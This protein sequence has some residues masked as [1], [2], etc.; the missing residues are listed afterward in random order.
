MKRRQFDTVGRF[1]VG[2]RVRWNRP[3]P[4]CPGVVPIGQWTY[5]QDDG[6]ITMM[7]EC[8]SGVLVTITTSDGRDLVAH[9][10]VGI[11][12]MKPVAYV[13]DFQ[14]INVLQEAPRQMEITT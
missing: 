4:A 2:Q 12:H 11:Y 3:D 5:I 14:T 6:T 1:S 8:E 7:R 13:A 10:H 9:I